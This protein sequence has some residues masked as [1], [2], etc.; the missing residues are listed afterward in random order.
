MAAEMRLAML[1]VG[2][3]SFDA[4]AVTQ[5]E[6]DLENVISRGSIRPKRWIY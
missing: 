2:M 5:L 4:E 6:Q 1:C 3:N